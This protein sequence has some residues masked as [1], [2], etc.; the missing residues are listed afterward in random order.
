MSYF[1]FIQHKYCLLVDIFVLFKRDA[2]IGTLADTLTSFYGGFVIFAILGAMSYEAKL[3]ITEVATSGN[4]LIYTYR[5]CHG[6]DRMV[7][8][9]T[10]TCAVSSYHH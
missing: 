8:G 4:I 6:R 9:F 5:G 7:V 1:S 3:P 10:A 2:V